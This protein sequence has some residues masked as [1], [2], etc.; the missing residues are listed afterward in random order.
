MLL[1]ADPDRSARRLLN[2]LHEISGANIGLIITDSHGRPFRLGTVG[3]ALGT[4]GLPALWD[5]RGEEDLFGY[6]LRVTEVG[7]ADEIASAASLL[8]GQGNEGQPVVLVRGL[9]YPPTADSQATDLIRP[10]DLDLYA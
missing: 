2:S 9:Q 3:I 7:F 4:A 6:Q 10:P 5:R 8:M 1:P